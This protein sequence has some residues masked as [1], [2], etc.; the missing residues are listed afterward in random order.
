MTV[1]NS[2]TTPFLIL[3]DSIRADSIRKVIVI[4]TRP[5]VAELAF[6]LYGRS[7]HPELFEIHRSRSYDRDPFRIQLDITSTGHVVTWQYDGITLT[8]VAASACHPLPQ[9]RRIISNLMRGEQK[10][11]V[12]CRGG[13]RYD[14]SFQF[15]TVSAD[16]FWSFQKQ[17][18]SEGAQEGILHCF[19]PSGRISL[20]AIS[21]MHVVT[22]ARKTTVRAFHTFPDD[23]AIVRTHSEFTLP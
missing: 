15:E 7:L 13:I 22:R 12:V 2:E 9:K 18:T 6:K 3:A 4:P 5:K 16:V 23:Y 14:C 20:G 1:F 19:D 21:Y 10:D 8:E 11:H 17:V